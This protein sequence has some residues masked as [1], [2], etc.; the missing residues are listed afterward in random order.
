VLT[1]TPDEAYTVPRPESAKDTQVTEKAP[2]TQEPTQQLEI[3]AA[4]AARRAAE[5]LGIDLKTIKGTGAGGMITSADVRRASDA[6]GQDAGSAKDRLSSMAAMT[7]AS[8]QQIPHFYV[9]R[10]ALLT[11]A[12]QW[13][14]A[15]NS[16]PS[17]PHATWND[18]FVR[19]AAEALKKCDALSARDPSGGPE[20]RNSA[21]ILVVSAREPGLSLIPVPDPSALAWGDFLTR[22]RAA[23]ATSFPAGFKPVLAVSNLGMFGVKQ[24]AAIIPPGC[25]AVLAIGGVREE[26]AFKNGKVTTEPICTFTLSADHRVVDGI[27]AALFLEE[28]QKSLDSL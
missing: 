4:P 25:T 16:A 10:D 22:V 14:N 26:L 11:H 9:T 8:K 19:C 6:R 1:D 17:N 3:A 12:A 21:D 15:W 7:V 13:R 20:Q 2:V 5:K 18:V 27:G 28:I 24:F 23:K